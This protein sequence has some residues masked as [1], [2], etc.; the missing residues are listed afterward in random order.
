MICSFEQGAWG[1]KGSWKT[2]DDSPFGPRKER[3]EVYEH[4]KEEQSSILKVADR[5]W[6]CISILKC[7][8]HIP[9]SLCSFKDGVERKQIPGITPLNS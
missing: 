8:R 4:S 9:K 7:P 5:F 2:R 6:R 1:T 3:R